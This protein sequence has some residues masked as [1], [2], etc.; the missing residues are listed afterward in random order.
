M[1]NTAFKTADRQTWADTLGVEG[2]DKNLE[3]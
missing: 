2:M 1:K 3:T